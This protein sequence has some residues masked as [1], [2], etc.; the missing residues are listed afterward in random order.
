MLFPIVG[1]LLY[2]IIGG[3]LHKSKVLKA[4]KQSEEN[5]SKHFVQDEKIK[6]EIENQNNGKI[7]YLMNYLNFPV[8]KNNYIKYYKL[9]ELAIKKCKKIYILRIFYNKKWSNVE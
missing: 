4:I 2:I 1:A 7:N 9:G 6:E 8:T 3:N 5:G